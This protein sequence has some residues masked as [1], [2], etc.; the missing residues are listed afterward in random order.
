LSMTVEHKTRNPA[1]IFDLGGV[2]LDWNPR[3]LY[4]K[5]FNGDETKVDFFLKEICPQSWNMRQDTGYPTAQ[6]IA[7]RCLLFPQYSA[8]IHAY[9]ERYEETVSGSNAGTVQIL[10]ELRDAGYPLCALSNWS[11]ETFDRIRGKFEFLEWFDE[12]VISGKVGLTKPDK[13][14]FMLAAERMRRV[15]ADCLFIDDLQVNI[16]AASEYDFQTILFTSPQELRIE[17]QK[18]QVLE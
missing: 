13:A 9:Y 2:L 7:E 6:A 1:L 17:L 12:L 4:W 15:P 10:G 14:F 3:Y 16:E 11:W 8:E 5:V 18:R